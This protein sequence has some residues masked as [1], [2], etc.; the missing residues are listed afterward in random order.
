[1]FMNNKVRNLLE[2]SL[3]KFANKPNTNSMPELIY[4][5]IRKT[6]INKGADIDKLKFMI[7]VNFDKNDKV[8]I[9]PINGYTLVFLNNFG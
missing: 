2:D 6:L 7:N 9:S 1:M 8:K 4:N 5:D 3:K